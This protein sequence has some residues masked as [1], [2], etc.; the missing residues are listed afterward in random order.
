MNVSQKMVSL[1]VV[2]TVL[3]LGT[4]AAFAA[5]QP[6][7]AKLININS[8]DASQLEKLPWIGAKMALRIIEFRKANGGFKRIQDLMKV[9]GIGPKLFEK[10]Q[11]QITI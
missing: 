7:G 6:T 4:E 3:L 11:N 2:L 8:A 5:V 9:K 1:L 10:L